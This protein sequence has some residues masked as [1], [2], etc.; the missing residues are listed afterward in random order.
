MRTLISEAK[1]HQ[2]VKNDGIDFGQAVVAPSIA[3]LATLDK[4]WKRRIEKLP[5]PN[6]L[7][8]IYC[9]TELDEFVDDFEGQVEKRRETPSMTLR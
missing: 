2:I 7:A 6:Q 9:E 8:R 1:S 4:H 5:R 3:K